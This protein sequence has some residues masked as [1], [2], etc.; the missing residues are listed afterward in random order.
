[1]AEKRREQRAGVLQVAYERNPQRF[2]HGMPKPAL[3]PTAVWINKPKEISRTE[4]AEVM[5]LSMTGVEQKNG[6]HNCSITNDQPS[7]R[8]LTRGENQLSDDLV[9]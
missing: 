2:V 9:V 6:F 5:N 8:D 1:L 4:S 3:L 7:G